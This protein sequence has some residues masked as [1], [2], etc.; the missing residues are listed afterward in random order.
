MEVMSF[1]MSPVWLALALA[2]LPG[3]GAAQPQTQP[4][5]EEEQYLPLA[6]LGGI[7]IRMVARVE[8]DHRESMEGSEIFS[9]SFAWSHTA[10]GLLAARSGW[11]P[12]LDEVS[13]IQGHGRNHCYSPCGPEHDFTFNWDSHVASAERRGAPEFHIRV[14][15]R[16][17]LVLYGPGAVPYDL[18]RAPECE[19]LP[20]WT[21]P[22]GRYH[23]DLRTEYPDAERAPDAADSTYAVVQSGVV[24]LRIPVA[25]L[26]G[27]K[28]LERT[29]NLSNSY[30]SSGFL[31][32]DQLR[33][34]LTLSSP[35][36]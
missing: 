6:P 36:G 15:G 29:V 16:E 4:P 11:S 5:Q 30:E 31:Y 9:E 26:R 18:R 35:P 17:A 23:F 20:D 27:G 12:H 34:N 24:L 3:N 1:F 7:P 28:S 22:P 25:E 33:I 10:E 2:L 21:N 8:T 19:C 32:E 14:Y 13:N